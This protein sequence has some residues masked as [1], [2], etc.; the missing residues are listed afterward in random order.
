MY[1][2]TLQ[3]W[4]NG[5]AEAWFFLV[6]VGIGSSVQLRYSLNFARFTEFANHSIFL[7]PIYSLALL[8]FLPTNTKL[9]SP[10]PPYSRSLPFLTLP[11]TPL[12]EPRSMPFTPHMFPSTEL[13]RE[14]QISL[15]IFSLSLPVQSCLLPDLCKAR[16]RPILWSISRLI[17][18]V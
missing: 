17:R 9:S 13:G 2:S 5:Q 11:F 14:R 15:T 4:R 16:T 18:R 1:N 6:T 3:P 10:S 12:S 8:S 7:S